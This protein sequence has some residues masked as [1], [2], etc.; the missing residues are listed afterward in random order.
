[1]MLTLTKI[2]TSNSPYSKANILH[3]LKRERNFTGHNW[4]ENDAIISV[5]AGNVFRPSA[6]WCD[7]P[8]KKLPQPKKERRSKNVANH[9]LKV[10]GLK[11][12]CQNQ[13]RGASTAAW[14]REASPYWE[15]LKVSILISI[16]YEVQVFMKPFSPK[17]CLLRL[18]E[19]ALSICK[20]PIPGQLN[21]SWLTGQSLS[22]VM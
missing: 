17:Q 8:Q 20:C 22:Y 9:C 2:S 1:M 6:I 14:G 19:I 21:C 15:V 16:S 3:P 12:S 4:P 11:N 13:Y 10:A 7:G 18:S 5:S